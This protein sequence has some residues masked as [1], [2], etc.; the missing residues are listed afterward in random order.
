MGW[1]FA[2]PQ[3]VDGIDPPARNS[4]EFDSQ[5]EALLVGQKANHKLSCTG[6]GANSLPRP[7]GSRLLYSLFFGQ[8][9]AIVLSLVR[10]LSLL[11]ST[12]EGTHPPSPA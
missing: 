10:P 2:E 4:I 9:R 8:T 11:Y 6:I 5:P 3:P 7:P 1:S 12:M